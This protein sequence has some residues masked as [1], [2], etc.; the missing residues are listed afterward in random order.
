MAAE[1]CRFVGGGDVGPLGVEPPPVAL[2]NV[3]VVAVIGAAILAATV[4]HYAPGVPEKK[5][6]HRPGASINARPATAAKGGRVT[7]KG[8]GSTKPKP[9]GA[10]SAGMGASTASGRYT[11]PIPQ[12]YKV[13]PRWVPILMG[14]F[15]IAGML[16]IILNYL[17]LM[18]GG[19][20]SNAYLL[21]GLGLITAGFIV[22]TRWR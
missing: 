11:P 8:T 9:G 14:I 18:P 22:A 7:P 19:E 21:G 5:K 6:E 10:V 3:E 13:S 16:T 20:P 17:S 12:E 4:D 15:L 1:R 2:P